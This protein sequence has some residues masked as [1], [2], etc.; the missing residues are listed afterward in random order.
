MG[1]GVLKFALIGFGEAGSIFGEDLVASGH[2]VATYDVLLDS[3]PAM[4][5]KA[6]RLRVR[7]A[8]TFDDEIGR[9]HV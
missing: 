8:E 3:S 1:T 7:A 4:R 2:E 5:E 6:R 9:A